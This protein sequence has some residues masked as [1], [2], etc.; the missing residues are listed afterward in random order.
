M[1][2]KT[3]WLRMQRQGRKFGYERQYAEKTRKLAGGR[4]GPIFDFKTVTG[5]DH[6]DN[7]LGWVSRKRERVAVSKV[8]SN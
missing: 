2:G 5:D 3:G 6:S 1:A 8:S 4:E 7:G